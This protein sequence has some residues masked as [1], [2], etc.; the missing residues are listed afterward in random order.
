MRSPVPPMTTK[1]WGLTGFAFAPAGTPAPFGSPTA[2]GGAL[3]A[4]DGEYDVRCCVPAA[5]TDAGASGACSLWPVGPEASAG[6]LCLCWRSRETMESRQESV[7]GG[8]V[9]L[10]RNQQLAAEA[11]ARLACQRDGALL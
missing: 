8:Q 7:G 9:S 10:L 2:M 1:R 4:R 11:W 6:G 5:E 3:G